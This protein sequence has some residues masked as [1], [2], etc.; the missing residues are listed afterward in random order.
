MK[1]LIVLILA[2]AMLITMGG[3]GSYLYVEKESDLQAEEKTRETSMF[4][5]VE[6]AGDWRIVYHKETKVMYA[7]SAGGYNCGNF[8]LLVNADGTPMVYEGS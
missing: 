5:S 2:C 8:T 7:V 4:V 6:V 3:C 1:K